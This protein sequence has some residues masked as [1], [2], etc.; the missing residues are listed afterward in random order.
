M[1]P[2]GSTFTFANGVAVQP[3]GKIVVAGSS[4]SQLVVVRYNADGSLDTSFD[5]DGMVVTPISSYGDVASLA[6]QADGKIVVAGT[7]QNGTNKNFVV[8]RYCADASLDASFGGGG[9]VLT[10]IDNSHA[11]AHGVTIQADGKIVVVGTSN[12][13]G[14]DRFAV[15]R[16]Q[17][18]GS[19]SFDVDGMVLTLI[20][21]G[22]QG[23]RA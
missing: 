17:P 2:V 20:G 1:T 7:S 23:Q 11:I 16:Y 6:L 9:I 18:D 14:I 21:N 19:L 22:G 4:W 8:V 5:V 12:S 13:A 10:Q 15:V 3:D